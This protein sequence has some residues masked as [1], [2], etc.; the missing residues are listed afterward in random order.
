M[1]NS[2]I[3]DWNRVVSND[4]SKIYKVTMQVFAFYSEKPISINKFRQDFDIP[5]KI[6]YRETGLAKNGAT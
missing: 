3:F 5:Q 6:L 1:I 2:V 4:L